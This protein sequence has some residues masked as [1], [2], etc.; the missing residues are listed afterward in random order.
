M[1]YKATVFIATVLMAGPVTVGAGALPEGEI[2][3]VMDF[4]TY[5]GEHPEG[6]A[7]DKVGNVFVSMAFLGEIWKITP[8]GD[9]SVFYSG[10]DATGFGVHAWVHFNQPGNG[11]RAIEGMLDGSLNMRSENEFHYP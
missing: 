4:D 10:L 1:F 7:V 8:R 5:L 11:C 3:L 2:G 9:F 6:V